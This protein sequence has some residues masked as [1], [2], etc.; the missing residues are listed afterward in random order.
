MGVNELSIFSSKNNFKRICLAYTT[1]FLR[2]NPVACN[3]KTHDKHE[4][5]KYYSNTP[6]FYEDGGISN[7][8]I[9]SS[10]GTIQLPYF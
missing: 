2:E 5:Y 1:E 10:T 3:T 6:T 4:G 7:V 8:R 9:S